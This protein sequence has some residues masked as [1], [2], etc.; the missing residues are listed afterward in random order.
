MEMTDYK[1]IAVRVRLSVFRRMSSAEDYALCRTADKRQSEACLM[2]YHIEQRLD[3]LFSPKN[4]GGMRVFLFAKFYEE[5]L[6][7]YFEKMVI[8]CC[9]ESPGFSG[10]KSPFHST[11]LVITTEDLSISYTDYAC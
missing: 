9:R 10:A 6:R 11:L 4:S 3:E 8:R 1:S 7:E 5:V 2:S